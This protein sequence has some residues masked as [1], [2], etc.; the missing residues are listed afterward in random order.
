MYYADGTSVISYLVYTCFVEGHVHYLAQIAI[1]KTLVYCFNIFLYLFN[2]SF[3]RN[4]SINKYSVL[5]LDDYFI[6]LA[7]A[8][9]SYSSYF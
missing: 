5:C 8:T 4:S 3:R 9:I 6:A 2:V 1:E 7:Y